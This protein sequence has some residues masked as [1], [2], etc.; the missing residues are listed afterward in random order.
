M[1]PNLYNLHPS[2]PS[3]P[4]CALIDPQT[5][6]S[7]A[8]AHTAPA[9]Q[10]L[11]GEVAHIPDLPEHTHPPL[12]IQAVA[13]PV[14]IQVHRTHS[15]AVVAARSRIASEEGILAVVLVVHHHIGPVGVDRLAYRVEGL[16]VV[17]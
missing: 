13:E 10:I 6:F 2:T 8:V 1:L 15:E 11:Q 3:L 17:K 16:V 5:P 4:T 14:H 7:L 12:G 9:H